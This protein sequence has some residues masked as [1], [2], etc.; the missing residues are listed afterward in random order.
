MENM[1][2]IPEK[3]KELAKIPF[4]VRYLMFLEDIGSDG[5]EYDGNYVVQGK[6]VMF[7]TQ[8][9]IKAEM[10]NSLVKHGLIWRC[11]TE[12]C[13]T[14]TLGVRNAT[15]VKLHGYV[16]DAFGNEQVEMTAYGQDAGDKQVA[17]ATTYALKAMTANNFLFS[18]QSAETE[19]MDEEYRERSDAIADRANRKAVAKD[20]IMEKNA[21][22]MDVKE[23]P[24]ST[25]NPTE[26]Q[27]SPAPSSE[28][29][30]SSAPPAVTGGIKPV[31]ASAVNRIVKKLDTL[32]PEDLE[33][34]G[35]KDAIVKESEAILKSDDPA[36]CAKFIKTYR[37]L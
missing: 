5:W 17:V 1:E 13:E 31:Q 3:Y 21:P 37:G 7:Y 22:Q 34:Y 27:P 2:N 29:I 8:A 30:S 35:G 11:V 25:V 18:E 23:E 24:T 28:A 15:R 16:M 32:N 20:I 19:S 4:R 12:N 6:P 26:A 33:Q 14:L 36:K 10:R 9:K